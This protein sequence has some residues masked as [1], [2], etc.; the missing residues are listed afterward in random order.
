MVA[1]VVAGLQPRAG[2]RYVDCT[3]GGGGHAEAI[4]RASDGAAW[5]LGCD[6]DPEA[7]QAAAARLARYAGRIE[8]RLGAFERVGEWWAAGSCDGAVADLGVSSHQL[9][10]PRR[11]FSFQRDG[12]LSMRMGPGA[13]PDA[14]DLVNGLPV[15][16]LAKLFEE[17]GEERHARR[18]ARV[19]GQE[20]ARTAIRS[21]R[22]LATLIERCVPRGAVAVHPATRVFQALRMAVN[23]ELGT[24]ER[25]LRAVWRL[26][27]PG[28]RLV[29][30]TF[31]SGEARVVKQ[32]GQ[33]LARAYDTPSGVDVPELRRPRPPR[34]R[35]VTRRALSPGE[36][37]QRANP[38]ARSAQLRVM[39]KLMDSPADDESNHGKEP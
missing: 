30:I 9:D 3:V 33:A 6:R 2:G 24:L 18:I 23:D 38:R 12:P 21:T 10:T 13:G 15:D 34:L 14:A 1:E 31:H 5:V 28:A 20:R 29:C 39:E 16:Q 8:L 27:R 25:G 17:L 26:L 22:Q 11:G 32:F 4:L 35:W 37:E 19:I 36:A 7:L